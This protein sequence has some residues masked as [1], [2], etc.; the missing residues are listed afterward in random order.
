MKIKLKTIRVVDAI[1]KK[2]DKIKVGGYMFKWKIDKDMTDD[3]MN[4]IITALSDGFDVPISFI[5]CDHEIISE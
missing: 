5:E 1:K 3:K 4:N 2:D